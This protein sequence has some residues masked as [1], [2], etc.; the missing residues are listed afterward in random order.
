MRV[1]RRFRGGLLAPLYHLP[2]PPPYRRCFEAAQRAWLVV[3]QLGSVY[4]SDPAESPVGQ[5]LHDLQPS[6]YDIWIHLMLLAC[7][8]KLCDVGW[9]PTITGIKTEVIL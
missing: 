4:F 9:T 7:D 2:N 5:P 3:A 1:A 6:T 8:Q